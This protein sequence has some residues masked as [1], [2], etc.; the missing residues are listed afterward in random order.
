DERAGHGHHSASSVLAELAFDAAGDINAFPDQLKEVKPWKP[1][2]LF[3]NSYNRGFTN[4][5]PDDGGFYLTYDIGSFN[6]LLGESYGEI[7][8]KARSMH[9]SQGFGSSLS[10]GERIEYLRLTKGSKPEKDLFDDVNL[11]W[12]RVKGGQQVQ[13]LIDDVIRTFN[14]TNPSAS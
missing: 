3:W 7:G 12:S 14:P 2:R 10:R 6:P 1:T 8:G 11:T 9:K 5:A 4:T 13:M